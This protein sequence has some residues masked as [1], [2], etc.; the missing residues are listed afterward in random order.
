[1]VLLGVFKLGFWVLLGGF[2]WV[3]FF[4]ANPAYDGFNGKIVRK[5]CVWIWIRFFSPAN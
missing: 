3:G 4:Q 2:F 5:S 1:M